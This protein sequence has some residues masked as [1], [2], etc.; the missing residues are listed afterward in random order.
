MSGMC[1]AP[2]PRTLQALAWLA[3]VGAAPQEPLRLVMGWSEMLVYDHV[4]RLVDAGLVRRVAMTRGHGSLLVTTP[5][6]AVMAGYRAGRAPRS[7]APTTWA[8]TAACAW[9][10]AWLQLRGQTRWAADTQMRWW[11]ER[12]VLH[13][14][15]WRRDVRYTDRRGHNIV[16][17]RPDLGVRI[18]GR[19]VPV[20]VELQRKA[21]VRL[22]AILQT[23][24]ELSLGE[25]AVYGGVIYV[26]GSA[27]VARAVRSAATDVGLTAPRFSVRALHD[28][29]EQ[30]IQASLLLGEQRGE[31]IADG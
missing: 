13:D 3:R 12:E 7:I 17:H 9:T 5:A 19:P 26:T 28:V 6:G 20:E 4:R 31:V 29:V 16:T 22:V 10:A 24:A 15:F 25:Q 8:H 21:R 27:D 18:A 2:G 23:Y 11:S 1:I 30:T 14:A